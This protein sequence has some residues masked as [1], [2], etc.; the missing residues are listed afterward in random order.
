MYSGSAPPA[1]TLVPLDID[2]WWQSGAADPLYI[3]EQFLKRVQWV[4]AQGAPDPEADWLQLPA[5]PGP[6]KTWEY[7]TWITAS[8]LTD[9]TLRDAVQPDG[10]VLDD[11]SW[12]P[13]ERVRSVAQARG[14]FVALL[15][16]GRRFEHLVDRRALLEAL[17]TATVSQ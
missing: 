5:V 11:R 4:Q 7:A 2:E 17:G 3:A 14:D 1:N 16:P 15:G 6:D 13:E 8:D 9:G 10:Y 12:S